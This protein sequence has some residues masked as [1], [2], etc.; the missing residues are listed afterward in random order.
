MALAPIWKDH[1]VTLGNS[2]A[3]D[4]ELR[5]D[6]T[7]GTQIFTGRAYK[8]PGAASCVVRINDIVADYLA[9]VLPT[10]VPA[11]FTSF[12]VAVT[13]LTITGGV[14]K[15][16]TTFFNDWSYDPDFDPATMPLADPVRAV[17]DP[18]Q[19][20]IFSSLPAQSLTAT[21]NFRY[22]P[23]STVVISL[24]RSADFNNDFNED[25]SAQNVAARGGAAVL[26]LSA[27]T[28]LASVTI[29]GVTYQ[30][31]DDTCHEW[32]LYY[33]NALGGWDSLL[34][35]GNVVR[36]DAVARKTALLEYDN[37]VAAARGKR[38]YLA[39][40]TPSWLI[41]TGILTDDESLRMHHLLNSV[42]V[43]LCHLATGAMT[44]VVLTDTENAQQTFKTN[45][46]AVNRYQINAQLAQDRI[47][48]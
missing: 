1:F 42:D 39:E 8:R 22:G 12:A 36:S 5:L 37:N 27:F 6:T 3:Y 7:S 2:N 28:S 14:T 16:T 33:V 32:A 13:V 10:L 41:N 34:I 43:Y 47:R 25:F 44:P 35:D 40:I 23:S 29:G 21:L 30:V 11:G 15:D 20:L 17:L 4:Y 9:N 48:R 46:R 31:L 26:D 38:D 24:A 19:H 18:R 45:G